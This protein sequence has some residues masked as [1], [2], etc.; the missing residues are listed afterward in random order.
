MQTEA[1]FQNLH[2]HEIRFVKIE[3]V[4]RIQ[5]KMQM[6]Q[7]EKNIASVWANATLWLLEKNMSAINQLSW[8]NK[9]EKSKQ[10]LEIEQ[11]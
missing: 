2:M 9:V 4:K 6:Q 1:N 10:L 7:V 8:Y 11:Q 3:G 5:N